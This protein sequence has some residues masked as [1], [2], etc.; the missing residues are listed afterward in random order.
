MEKFD[1]HIVLCTGAAKAS[2]RRVTAQLFF[3]KMFFL[4]VAASRAMPM[5]DPHV[6]R[7]ACTGTTLLTMPRLGH[8]ER[9]C[10]RQRNHSTIF[11]RTLPHAESTVVNQTHSNSMMASHSIDAD[12]LALHLLIQ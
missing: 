2:N 3:P 5:T 6:C 10:K 1:M 11:Y 12:A 9:A 7:K 8:P 4:E